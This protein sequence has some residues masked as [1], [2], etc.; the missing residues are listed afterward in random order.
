MLPQLMLPAAFVQITHILDHST[1]LQLGLGWTPLR[2]LH[3]RAL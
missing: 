2:W 3:L 1:M